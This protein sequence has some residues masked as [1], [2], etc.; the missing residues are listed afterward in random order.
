MSF[1]L[2]NIRSEIRRALRGDMSHDELFSLFMLVAPQYTSRKPG[3]KSTG[4]ALEP[5]YP[6]PSGVDERPR[7]A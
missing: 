5:K 7:L 6:V 2:V 4:F 3:R 1:R